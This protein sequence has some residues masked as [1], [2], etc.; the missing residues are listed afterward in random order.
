MD[1]STIEQLAGNLLLVL[2]AG[3]VAG[4][5]CRRLG[6]SMLVG[7]LVAGALIGH[8]GIGWMPKGSYPLKMLADAGV[9]F[10][11]FSIGIELSFE[12]L[13]H[14]F[15][16]LLFGGAAQ[17]LLVAVPVV[18]AARLLGLAW[19]GAV[20]LGCA[21]ALSS[22]V[23]VFKALA[24]WGQ[25][26]TPHGRRAIGILLFQAVALVPLVLLVPLLTGDASRA[27]L[28]DFAILA[29]RSVLV[30]SA[31]IVVREAIG[32]WIAPRLQAMRSVE[33]VV[34]FTLTVLGAFC[35]LAQLSDLP[36]MLGALAAGVALGGS[37]LTRQIDAITLPYRETFAAVFFVS[38]G[39]LM[40][41]D[42]LA[43]PV[44]AATAL[45]LLAAV[46]AVKTLGAAAALRLTGL[47][48]RGALGTG[49][50]LAQMGEF[51]FV[52]L[53]LGQDS[54]LMTQPQR[55]LAMFVAL[56]TLILTP[57]LLKMGLRLVEQDLHA[58]D[59]Q[60]ELAGETIRHAIVVG[61]GPI[62][63]QVVSLLETSGVDV[64]LVDFSPVNL[65]AYALQGF[66]TV[67]GDANE[68]TV[69][70]RAGI[71]QCGLAVVT[72]AQDAV[73][74]NIVESIRQLQETC[75]IVVRCRYQGNV[76]RIRKAGADRVV[77]EEAEA[78]EAI[79][80][81]LREMG[82]PTTAAETRD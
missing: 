4:T 66:R 72:V 53:L 34:L 64:C 28:L 20:L 17:M 2:G 24:E 9:L 22:T 44:Q 36:P 63:R 8:G 33:L 12:S 58:V 27:L 59:D 40:R 3:L 69:L 18:A 37:R 51:S 74:E 68:P 14:L 49:L 23:L 15:R 52:L 41:F 10:L 76:G 6:V 73:A 19:S 13:R 60:V 30:I 1:P 55:D 70:R 48:W 35:L 26:T 11:L 32:R 71:G 7:Y 82:P 29:L 39:T 80:R 38:L 50:G 78:S 61:V 42:V 5:V 31:V 56:G 57:Q 81:L 77:S 75:K 47:R 21:V 46:L 43:S 62:G 54:G 16:W 67:A 79:V 65:H 25:T 45:T